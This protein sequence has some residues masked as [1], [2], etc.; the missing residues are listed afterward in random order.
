MRF[1]IYIVEINA[2]QIPW[3][4]IYFIRWIS[5]WCDFLWLKKKKISEGYK[6][7]QEKILWFSLILFQ[8][9]RI[10]NFN[11]FIISIDEINVYQ[12]HWF[13]RSKYL[14]PVP[15]TPR[16]VNC[17]AYII[18]I[19]EIDVIPN[20]LIF[21]LRIIISFYLACIVNF[22]AFFISIVEINVYQSIDFTVKTIDCF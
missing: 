7:F 18:S 5:W 2:C 8:K 9:K 22:N 1:K 10:V 14:T 21:T 12:I 15:H 3:K 19:V 6:N 20:K 17:N 11:A 13:S 16:I 4:S